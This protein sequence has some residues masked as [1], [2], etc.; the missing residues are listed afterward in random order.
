MRDDKWTTAHTESPLLSAP[1]GK[2][3][4]H[5]QRPMPP[6]PPT[7]R[8]TVTQ[9]A[10]LRGDKTTK[11]PALY[12]DQACLCGLVNMWECMDKE[13]GHKTIG[14]ATASIIGAFLDTNPVM[15]DSVFESIGS[16]SAEPKALSGLID[17]VAR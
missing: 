12:V 17:F 9:F 10:P 3:F 1:D 16:G 11:I 6:M 15:E 5:S 14:P 7:E 2:R 13:P 4:K 8:P